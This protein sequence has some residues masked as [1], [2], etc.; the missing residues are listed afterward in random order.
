MQSTDLATDLVRQRI[1]RGVNGGGHSGHNGHSARGAPGGVVVR[2]AV[3]KSN[4]DGSASL[5]P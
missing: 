4:L 2:C 5:R 1:R 3:R